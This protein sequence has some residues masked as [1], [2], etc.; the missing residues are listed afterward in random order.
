MMNHDTTISDWL[1][2]SLQ[3][4]YHIAETN[5]GLEVCNENKKI[6]FYERSQMTK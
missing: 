5:K 1:S 6:L 4:I 2:F 3:H